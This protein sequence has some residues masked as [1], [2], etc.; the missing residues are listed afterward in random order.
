MEYKDY[1][2]LLGVGRTATEQEIK[3]AYRRLARQV[4]PDVNP[5]DAKAEERF[6]E[7]NEAYQ[8][9]TD[10]EKRAKYDQLGVSWQQWQRSGHDPG[11]YDWSQ[12]FADGAGGPGRDRGAWS[13]G[14]EGLFVDSAQAGL[15]SDFFRFIFG[16][17]DSGVQAAE[18][19]LRRP[20]AQRARNLET[21]VDISLEEAYRGAT[22][23]LQR[24]KNRIRVA[25]PPGA[26]TGSRIRYAGKG[27][28]GLEQG[29]PGDLYVTVRVA[30][31]PRFRREGADLH[32]DVTVDLY[33]AVLGG[34]VRVRTLDGDV[35]LRVP[36]GTNSGRTFRLKGKGMPR[37]RQPSQYGD[38]LVTLHVELPADLSPREQELFEELARL[39][40][41]S[42]V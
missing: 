14:L 24:G 42:A 3:R 10:P 27:G 18:D 29:K 12:W 7:I 38:L 22:R 36:S 8:V 11:Q 1:Y 2:K 6:K 37:A 30:P 35:A 21:T 31:D 4:H 15:F 33:T 17:A 23:T 28:Q 26:S 20:Y 39:R 16:N 34:D 40:R 25:I 5:D 32:A 41:R 13:G 9:L 19:L